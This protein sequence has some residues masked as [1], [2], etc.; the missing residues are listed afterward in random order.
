LASRL[1]VAALPLEGDSNLPVGYQGIIDLG[2]EILSVLAQRKFH[3]DL[4]AHT[5]L[6]YKKSWLEQQDPFALARQ[7]T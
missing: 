3:E 5:T 1:G 2:E 6:P 4:A 7:A